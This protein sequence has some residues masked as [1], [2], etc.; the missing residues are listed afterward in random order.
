MDFYIQ[1]ICQ[2]L[3]QLDNNL[4]YNKYKEKYYKYNNQYQ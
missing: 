1:I 3:I 2:D 4:Q